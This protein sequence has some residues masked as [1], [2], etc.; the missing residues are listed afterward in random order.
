MTSGFPRDVDDICALLGYYA[1]SSGNP[2][3]T[4]RGQRIGLIFKGQEV[5]DEKKDGRTYTMIQGK[6]RA[7]TGNGR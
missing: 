7:V 2:L 6:V 4:F 3:P 1:A 5:Q